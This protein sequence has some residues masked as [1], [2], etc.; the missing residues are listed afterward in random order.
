M[1]NVINPESKKYMVLKANVVEGN[2]IRND[3]EWIV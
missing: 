3:W 1:Y 2:I